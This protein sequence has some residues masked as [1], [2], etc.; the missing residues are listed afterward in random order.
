MSDSMYSRGWKVVA[1][2][3]AESMHSREGAVPAPGVIP[4]DNAGQPRVTG[5]MKAACIGEF[6]LPVEVPVW[7][8]EEEAFTYEMEERMVTVPWDL[9]KQIYKAMAAQAMQEDFRLDSDKS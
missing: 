6:E 5:A 9:C 4:V 7:D 8:P 1:K 3:M 2:V